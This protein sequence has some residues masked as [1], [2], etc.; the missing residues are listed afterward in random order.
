MLDTDNEQLKA[1]LNKLDLSKFRPSFRESFF[2]V[3][4]DILL[5]SLTLI[6]VYSVTTSG[7]YFI[8]LLLSLFAGN[9]F[10]S[11]F[12]LG[13]DCGHGSFSKHKTVNNVVGF[14]LH[15]F[16]LTPYWAWKKSHHRHH[17]FTG[18]IERDESFVPITQDNAESVL[19]VEKGNK[20][21]FFVVRL[22]NLI[23]LI[24]GISFHV[25]TVYNPFTKCSHFLPNKVFLK[26]SDNKWIYLGTA[27]AVLSLSVL[28][29]LTFK[30]PIMM[31]F[32]YWLPFMVCYHILIFVTLM[33]HHHPDDSKWYYS[34]DWTRLKGALNT[35]DYRYGALNIIVSK[36]HHN[37]ANFHVIHHIFASIPHYKIEAATKD[38]VGK[39][40]ANYEPKQFSYSNYIRIIW[41]CNY[42]DNH[43]SEQKHYP[44]K[45]FEEL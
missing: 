28:V 33:Q 34:Q 25:Y 35:F 4:L 9:L 22:F 17:M 3:L 7:Y 45:S 32:M 13:H 31:F 21:S 12:V 38:L 10:F 41:S 2:Y 19:G 11:L 37:I 42:V 5:L 29:Y 30:Q 26:E 39:I 15:Q 27:V 14:C 24:T 1:A 36:L 18:D 16:I 23:T 44:M 20:K 40:D 6:A 43:S 8:S